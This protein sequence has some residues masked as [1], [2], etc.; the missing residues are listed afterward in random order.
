VIPHYTNAARTLKLVQAIRDADGDSGGG[1]AGAAGDIEIVVVDDASPDGSGAA[2]EDASGELGIVFLTNETNRGFSKTMNRGAAL[3]TGATLVFS[4]TDIEF[5]ATAPPRAVLSALARALAHD[6]VGAA[7]PLVY[8]T[9][10]G[11]VENANDLW[12]N[13]GLLWLRRLPATREL[14]ERAIAAVDATDGGHSISGGESAP[15]GEPERIDSVLCGAF[16]AMQRML[17]LEMGGFDPAFS[18]YYWEDVELGVRIG[19]RGLSVALA[20]DALALHEHNRSI[21]AAASEK[22]RWAA[23][24]S[25]QLRITRMWGR[26]LGVRRMKPW[27][28]LRALRALVRGDFDMAREYLL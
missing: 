20:T 19:I 9:A 28:L 21:G 3:A 4:N 7:M 18:P 24:Q 8:N 14:S 25:N 26:K 13:R 17:F 11:E 16:F 6:R 1:G 23:M 22:R 5:T 27:H 12:A 2:I 15:A 10:L